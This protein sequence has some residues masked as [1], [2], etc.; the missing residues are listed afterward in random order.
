M[1]DLIPG[2]LLN[3]S[4]SFTTWFAC[5]HF[6]ETNFLTLGGGIKKLK[7]EISWNVSLLSHLESRT[8]EREL[9]IQKIIH[10]QNIAH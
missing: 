2:Q 5:C 8:D 10:L 9:E 1:L 3:I 6:D 7:K 4:N